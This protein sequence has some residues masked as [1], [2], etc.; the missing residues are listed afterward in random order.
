MRWL[1]TT[2]LNMYKTGARRVL[3]L[4][5]ALFG[6][7]VLSPEEQRVVSGA[8]WDEFCDTLKAA[9]AA[10]LAPGAPRD[11]FNQAEGYRYLARLARAGLE[12]YLECADVEVSLL[13]PGIPCSLEEDSLAVLAPCRE[14]EREREPSLAPACLQ[15]MPLE[16]SLP[17]NVAAGAAAVRDREWQPCSADLHRQR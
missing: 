12:N 15:P 14:K 11:P 5:H 3:G 8:A 9:G 2:F 4:R 7:P 1:L 16:L 6:Q 17:D 10:M 13:P